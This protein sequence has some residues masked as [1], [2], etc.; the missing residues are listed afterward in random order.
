[1]GT[2][3]LRRR[4]GDALVLRAGRGAAVVVNAGPEPR[5][6]D[7]CLRRLGVRRV[8]LVVLT[9]F[10]ADHVG[11]LPGVLDGREVGTILTSPAQDPVAGARAVAA[12][13]SPDRVPVRAAEAG[14]RLTV[15]DV[16]AEVL[17]P[18]AGV[19]APPAG[20]GSAANDASV[21]LLAEVA[22][23]RLLLTGDVEPPAQAGLRDV[24]AGERVDVLKVPHH[25]SRHQDLDLLTGL[26]PRAAVVS[27]G[28]TTTTGTRP[29]TS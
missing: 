12:A 28:W 4:P 1:M 8:P 24:L 5:P 19:R 21:V 6:V 15:G 3:G 27:V 14:S 17:W 10:H 29:P 2:R 20:D 25:G 22:G 26:E 11:G 16:S 18:R 23:L 7:A 9:H 13:A